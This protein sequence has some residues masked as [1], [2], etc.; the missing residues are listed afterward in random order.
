MAL[1]NLPAGV[2]LANAWGYLSGVPYLRV[3]AP[4]AAGQKIS[5]PLRFNN[6]AKTAIGYQ[7][8]VYVAN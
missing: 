3:E 4:I 1:R 5:L 7:P 6:P 8:L 2:S